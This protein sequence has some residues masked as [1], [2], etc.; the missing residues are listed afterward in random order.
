MTELLALEWQ[1][2]DAIGLL[3][4]YGHQVLCRLVQ[5]ELIKEISVLN[6]TPQYQAELGPAGS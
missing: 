4:T 1:R 3:R 6:G 5:S 2:S